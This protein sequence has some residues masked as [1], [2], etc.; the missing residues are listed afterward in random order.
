MSFE[1]R[2]RARR[3]ITSVIV[4]LLGVGILGIAPLAHADD[5]NDKKKDKQSQINSNRQTIKKNQDALD[6]IEAK[7][8]AS[9]KALTAAQT[10]LADKQKA[11]T[12][13]KAID[14]RLAAELAAAQKV[15]ADKE[16]E[17]AAAKQAVTDGEAALAAQRDQIGV[18][19][20]TTAQQNTTLLS[21]SILFTDFDAADINDRLQWASTVFTANE[22][23]MEVLQAMQ[24]QLVA[25]Q[26]AA[27]AAE[28]AAADAAAVAKTK[29]EAAA[30]HLTETKKAEAEAQAAKTALDT[31]VT[32]NQKAE[33][34]AQAALKAAKDEDAKLQADLKAIEAQIQA[35]IKA[36][37]NKS[38]NVAPP[39]TGAFFYRPVPGGIGSGFGMRYHPILHYVRM[40]WGVDMH[41]SCGT[42]IRAA[43]SGYVK[44][45]HWNGGYGNMIRLDHGRIGGVYYGTAYGHLSRYAVSA[46]QYV[47][48]GQI[49]GY[50][51]TTGLSTGCHLHFEVYKNGGAVNPA[52]YLAGS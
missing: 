16:T 27:Q 35:E 44:A 14:T 47:T 38:P 46:G 21:L 31:Q 36:A 7:L 12:A 6:A 49:I 29:R 26:A 50:V 52:P 15:Q 8:D 13:A 5:L 2:T 24:Q 39:S 1:T 9:R 25:D 43:A 11:V 22:H 37:G 28:K 20:Q 4:G 17:L 34:D 48:R 33:A 30:A 41:A 32:D 3:G 40:H 45:A 42:P 51:G 18:I 10:T 23:A 19:A